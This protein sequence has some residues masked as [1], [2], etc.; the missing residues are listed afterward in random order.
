MIFPAP[1][2]T[3]APY[4]NTWEVPQCDTPQPHRETPDRGQLVRAHTGS[5]VIVTV[6]LE[7][8]A[9]GDDLRRGG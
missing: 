8:V 5:V 4:V 9:K 3:F 6:R 7:Q 1:C 2:Q